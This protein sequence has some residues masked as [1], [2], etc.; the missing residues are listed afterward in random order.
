M[1]VFEKMQ[2]V[3]DPEFINWYKM[4]N[5]KKVVVTQWAIAESMM[6]WSLR[7]SS[8]WRSVTEWFWRQMDRE[9]L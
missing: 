5:P 7:D 3:F 9:D 2:A 8:S 6:F 1:W 4:S